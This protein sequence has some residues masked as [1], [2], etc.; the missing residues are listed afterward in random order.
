[1]VS[2]PVGTQAAASATSRVEFVCRRCGCRRLADVTGM[3]QGVQSFL[4]SG[5]TA[6]RRAEKDARKDIQRTLRRA[7]CPQ[8]QQRN[9]GAVWSFLRPWLIMVAL[10]MGAAVI[11]G[12]APT[13]F[14]LNMS[15][16]D[17]GICKWVMPLIFGGTLLLIIPSM[18][19][20]KWVNTDQQVR[21]VD[22]AEK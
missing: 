3:G 19:W 7:R 14:D 4:N 16:H 17:R 18:L 1:M 13:W 10:F 5:G 2:I 21:W 15:E 8:C 11:A 22:G 12:Y 20:T 9:P 6:Q